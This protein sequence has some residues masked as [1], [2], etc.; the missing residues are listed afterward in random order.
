MP[1]SIQSI[2]LDKLLAHPDNPNRMSRANF[3]KLV[4]N[5]KATGRYEPLVVRPSAERDGFYQVINGHHRRQALAE[6]GYKKADAVVWDI[7]DQQAD[8]LLA[9]LNRLCGS[10]V[11]DKK[12]KLFRKLCEKKSIRDIARLLPA[13]SKQLEKLLHSKLPAMPA[14]AN[15]QVFAKPF[16]VFLA[17]VQQQTVEK[18]VS[19]AC[20]KQ[21]EKIRPAEKSSALT[22]IA[23]DFTKWISSQT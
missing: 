11:L 6:L 15:R 21:F 13:S 3:A 19:I 17:P 14:A 10:D 7:D 12:V 4:R 18:A 16:I 8:L 20:G 9:T 23:E 2:A 5:I 1:N 22:K